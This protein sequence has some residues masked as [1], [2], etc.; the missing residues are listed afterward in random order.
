MSPAWIRWPASPILLRRSAAP[1]RADSRPDGVGAAATMSPCAGGIGASG[2][3][4]SAKGVIHPGWQYGLLHVATLVCKITGR[5]RWL[6]AEVVPAITQS[7]VGK[8]RRKLIVQRYQWLKQSSFGSIF[9]AFASLCENGL[10][11]ALDRSPHTPR[12]AVKV[13]K[14][15]QKPRYFSWVH[16]F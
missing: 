5:C 12:P 3:I 15:I 14:L 10:V 8:N 6:S 13:R 9:A 2:F 4:S 16:G 1:C 7:V 11:F